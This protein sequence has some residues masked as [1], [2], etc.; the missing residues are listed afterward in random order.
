MPNFQAIKIS[1]GTMRPG[2]AGTITN[3]QIVLNTQT[4]PYFNQATKKNTC[5]N[6]PIQKYPEIEHFK[7]KKILRSSLTV[8][9]RST[10]P[11]HVF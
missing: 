6:F 8:E 1:G 11:P 7:P 5:Q 10:P 9:I 2:Y 4:N 3:L